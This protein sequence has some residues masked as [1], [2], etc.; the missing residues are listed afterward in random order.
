MQ[1]FAIAP[2]GDPVVI[3]TAIGASAMLLALTSL[4]QTGYGMLLARVG[5]CGPKCDFLSMLASGSRGEKKNEQ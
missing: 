3:L 4:R 2:G 1:L 5:R